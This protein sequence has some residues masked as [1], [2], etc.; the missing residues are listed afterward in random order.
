VLAV[1]P[2]V[3]L[4]FAREIG[5]DDRGDGRSEIEAFPLP[6]DR[7]VDVCVFRR[8]GRWGEVV[9]GDQAGA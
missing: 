6:V 7:Y 4:P 8:C 1:L 5:R 3:L 2:L 9:V